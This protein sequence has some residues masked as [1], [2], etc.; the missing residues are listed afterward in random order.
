M[1]NHG[2]PRR[3]FATLLCRALALLVLSACGGGGD[4][5]NP[6]SQ[7]PSS[8]TQTVGAAGGT[9]VGPGGVTL[10]IPAG[11]LRTNTALTIALDSSGAPQPPAGIT[12]NQN[13]M[14]ALLPHGT[15]FSAPVTVSLTVDPATAGASGEALILK[16]NAARNGWET[17]VTQ[18]N[19]NTVTGAITSFSNVVGVVPAPLPTAA[20]ITVVGPPYDCT[21]YEGGW[22]FFNVDAVSSRAADPPQYQWSRNGQPLAGETDK[23]ILVNPVEA[24]DDGDTYSVVVST[25]TGTPVTTVPA[26]LHV[27]AFAPVIVTQP[28]S[29]QVTA[30]TTAVFSAASTSGVAQTLQWKRCNISQTCP[31][32]PAQWTNT[33]GGTTVTYALGNAQMDDD[34]A[35]FAMCASNV[36]GTACSLPATLSVIPQP[37]QPVIYDQPDNVSTVAGRPA[38][39]IVLANGGSLAYEWQRSNNGGPFLVEVGQTAAAYTIPSASASDNGAR[40]RVLVSNT[41]GLALSAEASLAVSAGVGVTVKRLGGGEFHSLALRSDGSMLAW[42]NNIYG[43]LG[44]GGFASPAINPALA[45]GLSNVAMFSAGVAHNLALQSDGSLRYW[46]YG[47]YYTLGTG[48]TGHV[49]TAGTLASMPVN[50]AVAAGATHSLAVDQFG[51][52]WGWGENVCGTLGNGSTVPGTVPARIWLSSVV[53]VAAAPNRSHALGAD[54]TV[55]SWGCNFDGELGDGTQVARLQPTPIAGISRVVELSAGLAHTVALTSDGRV[56][57]WGANTRGQLGDASNT[58]RLAPVNVPLPGIAVAVAAGVSHSLALLSDG[59]VFAWGGNDA[60]QLGVGNNLDSNVPV[61]VGAPLPPD[62][63]SIGSGAN[64]LLALDAAGNAWAW[65]LNNDGQ[66]GDGTRLNRNSPV[67]VPGVN[68]N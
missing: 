9:I 31:A 10:T 66:L 1:S 5:G 7:P 64:H 43:Q 38:T 24:S 28:L 46:G 58:R 8:V 37:A 11:A 67:Q 16:T 48:Q 36:A 30:S 6:P 14:I 15:T 22:C 55:W 45:I 59:R 41:A 21:V 25:T 33:Q 26:V 54:G 44:N 29:L 35:R 47:D 18:R 19:G 4:G 50:R 65:G 68:L 20:V 62:I 42:G 17:V 52:L 60:G 53:S 23:L 39:F 3:T 61:R 27:L 34:G 63:A 51:G 40:L 2:A 12:M 56:W 32:D 57:A 13:A 49:A